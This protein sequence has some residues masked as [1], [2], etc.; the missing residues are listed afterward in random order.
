V[1]SR[2]RLSDLDQVEAGSWSAVERVGAVPGGAL[3]QHPSDV[4]NHLHDVLRFVPGVN[5]ETQVVL[6]GGDFDDRRRSDAAEDG[7]R[8]VSPADLFV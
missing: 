3:S 6:F 1:L 2:I 5:R 7:V 8:F 4:L